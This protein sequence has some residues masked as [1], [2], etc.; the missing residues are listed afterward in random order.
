MGEMGLIV[1]LPG[2][3]KTKPAGGGSSSFFDCKPKALAIRWSSR[4][5]RSLLG[6]PPYCLRIFSGRARPSN[7][8]AGQATSRGTWAPRFVDRACSGPQRRSARSPRNLWGSGPRVRS[9]LPPVF[10]V[11]PIQATPCC[12]QFRELGPPG[13]ELPPAPGCSG[14]RAPR[15]GSAL[16]SCGLSRL[17]TAVAP[18]RCAEG[19]KVSLATT[20][21]ASAVLS[22]QCPLAGSRSGPER[23]TPPLRGVGRSPNQP[24]S[25]RYPGS[26]EPRTWTHRGQEAPMQPPN[27][28]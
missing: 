7:P 3:S 27:H 25:L 19:G 4:A 28:G 11:S 24:L 15:R 22:R 13:P 16:P 10:R 21:A 8:G 6:C 14:C 23:H 2:G 1:L 5:P 9:L 18:P 12:F 17:Q 26:P 20:T